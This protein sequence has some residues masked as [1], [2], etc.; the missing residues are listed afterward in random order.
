MSD[1]SW[2]YFKTTET[3]PYYTCK[4]CD[5]DGITYSGYECKKCAG[6]GNA[7]SPKI[8]EERIKAKKKRRE[9]LEGLENE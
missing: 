9:H 3:I 1:S 6:T 8:R 4:E 5:G 7:L 2:P